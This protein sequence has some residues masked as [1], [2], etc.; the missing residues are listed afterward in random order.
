MSDNKIKTAYLSDA[1]LDWAVAVCEGRTVR[2]DPMGV[3]KY[4]PQ[5]KPAGY[6]IWEET[7]SGQGGV[8]LSKSIYMLIGGAYSPSTKWEQGGPII[9]NHSINLVNPTFG[10]FDT[11]QPWAAMIRSEDNNEVFGYGPT[12]LIAAMRCYVSSK[13][14]DAVNAPDGLRQ[15]S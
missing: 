6:W 10:C 8:I 5:S 2:Y 9:A 3:R 14:G 13:L 4:A 12:A 11:E 15:Q 7:P 1:A